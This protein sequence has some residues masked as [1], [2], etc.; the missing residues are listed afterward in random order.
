MLSARYRGNHA[1][2]FAV[3]QSTIVLLCIPHQ[4]STTNIVNGLVHGDLSNRLLPGFLGE[5]CEVAGTANCFCASKWHCSDAEGQL[6]AKRAA[7]GAV[8]I[9][10]Y[11]DV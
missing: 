4:G 11:L 6:P 2:I 5:R 3:I 7:A 10:A 9:Y 8:R 1:S